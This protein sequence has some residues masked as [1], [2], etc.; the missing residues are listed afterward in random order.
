MDSRLNPPPE[1]TGDQLVDA[2]RRGDNEAYGTA[3]RAYG[4][5]LLRTATRLLGMEEEARDC[6]QETFL[7]AF[8]KIDTFEERSELGTW[9]HRICI[10]ACLMKLRKR[11]RR[12]EALIDELMPE[13]DRNDCR[14]EPAWHIPSTHELLEQAETGRLVQASIAGLPDDYRIVLMLRDIEEYST[15]E[16]AEMLEITDGAVKT[17][18]HRARSALKKRLEPLFRGDGQ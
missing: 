7:Q 8:R 17:R 16:V 3:I 18:L 14:I 12:N 5:K 4:G 9:L 13:F 11:A 10:N 6:V 2:L 15:A 1:L